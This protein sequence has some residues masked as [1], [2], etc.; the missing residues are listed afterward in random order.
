MDSTEP[1]GQGEGAPSHIWQFADC[2]LDERR[3]ELRVRGVKV[4]VEAKPLEVLRTLLLHA[5]EVV[6]KGELL[7]SV[8]PGLSVVDGSLAT[9]ISKIRKL[10]GDDDRVI[11]TVPRV[12]Y[13][14]AVPVH[15]RSLPSAVVPELHL[16]SRTAS[17]IARSVAFDAAPRCVSGERCLAG[18][19]PQDA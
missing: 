17:S 4:D 9:A 13:K 16:L 19:T 18:R 3:R 14:L 5:G 10:L 2:E 12:G 6:T 11:V 7:D 1:T 8:W 15:C